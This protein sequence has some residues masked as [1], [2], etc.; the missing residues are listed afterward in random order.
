MDPLPS[1]YENAIH[2][3]HAYLAYFRGCT[4]SHMFPPL[5]VCTRHVLGRLQAKA[6]VGLSP[7]RV[8][9]MR[10]SGRGVAHGPKRC[11][12]GSQAHHPGATWY[13][14]PLCLVC[15]KPTCTGCHL[16]DY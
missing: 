8:P 7:I 2:S 1:P 14:V 12:Q 15:P 16:V 5:S 6:D 9:S 13:T 10:R 11:E 4:S 3:T